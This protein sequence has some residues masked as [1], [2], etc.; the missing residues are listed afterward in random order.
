MWIEDPTKLPLVLVE[1]TTTTGCA[2]DH[3]EQPL[4]QCTTD[5][6]RS[7]RGARL[8]SGDREKNAPVLTRFRLPGHDTSRDPPNG[9]RQVSHCV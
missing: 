7:R 6:C 9:S 4:Q 5:L 8:P 3:P 1:V 2:R